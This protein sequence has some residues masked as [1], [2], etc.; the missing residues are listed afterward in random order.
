[1]YVNISR[2]HWLE[3]V[4]F[5]AFGRLIDVLGLF[6]SL[7]ISGSNSF[8]SWKKKKGDFLPPKADCGHQARLQR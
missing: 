4:D 7:T 6:C 2:Y 1:M 3:F 8:L 5:G